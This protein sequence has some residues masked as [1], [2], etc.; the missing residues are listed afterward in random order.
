MTARLNR[1]LKTPDRDDV[2]FNS[3]IPVVKGRNVNK[4][5]ARKIKMLGSTKYLPHVTRLVSR[6]VN[7]GIQL[8]VALHVIASAFVL[9]GSAVYR[10][11]RKFCHSTHRYLRTGNGVCIEVYDPRIEYMYLCISF[12]F[13]WDCPALGFTD[14]VASSS[15]QKAHVPTCILRITVVKNV[16]IYHDRMSL[17][18][19]TKN[20]RNKSE[21]NKLHLILI[22]IC[23]M[24]E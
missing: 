16:T 8:T 3:F 19:V 11:C 23:L 18:T 20:C 2:Y 7:W 14:P 15:R 24:V 9:V 12:C 17:Q 22:F 1:R 21:Q 10:P 6:R 4:Y 13:S 5:K